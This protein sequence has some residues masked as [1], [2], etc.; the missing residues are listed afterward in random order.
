MNYCAER[1][2]TAIPKQVWDGLSYGLA[3]TAYS[4]IQ[5]A[6]RYQIISSSIYRFIILLYHRSSGIRHQKNTDSMSETTASR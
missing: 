4:I 3:V 5:S 1:F 6:L 2:E